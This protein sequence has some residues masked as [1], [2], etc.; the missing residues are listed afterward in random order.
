MSKETEIKEKV[1]AKIRSG[2]A[3]MRPRLYFVL[4]I[5]LLAALAVIAF[6][7]AIFVLSFA[8]FSIHESGEQFLLGFGQRG[9]LA[10]V[11]LFPW[12]SFLLTA[13][14]IL[15]I[16]HL[17]RYFKFGYRVSILE[18]FL[19]ALVVVMVGGVAI[20]FTPLHSSLLDSAD[21]D[22]LPIIGE[23]YEQ[24]HDPH[25]EQGV[26][27]GSISSIQGN[28]FVIT[29]NDNDKDSDDGTWNIVAPAGFDMNT[30]QVG[31]PVYVAGKLILGTVNAYGIHELTKERK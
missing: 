26:Y 24:I 20:N 25:Q 27:R 11:A 17:L 10:F 19:V 3:W 5:A 2:E 31:E 6:V 4:R 8:F 22:Q 23:M 21:H 30:L 14:L 15:L 18:I 13:L 29:H 1:F 9:L 7:L 16:D 28:T 12:W